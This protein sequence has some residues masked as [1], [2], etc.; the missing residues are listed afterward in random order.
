MTIF[1][2]FM[3]TTLTKINQGVDGF[4]DKAEEMGD[5]IE[6]MYASTVVKLNEA[7]EEMDGIITVASETINEKIPQAIQ[8]GIDY[9]TIGCAVVLVITL[10]VGLFTCFE[11]YQ[12]KQKLKSN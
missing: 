3:N 5:R 1:S 4:Y 2:E 7:K 11:R 10:L 9:A 6:T 12:A 8:T